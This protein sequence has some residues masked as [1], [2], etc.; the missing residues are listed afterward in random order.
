MKYSYLK[1]DLN[2]TCRACLNKKYRLNLK[3]KDCLYEDYPHICR[4][5]KEMKNIVHDV[6]FRKKLLLFFK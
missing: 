3:P 1:N 6:R 4:K 5:C 2:N